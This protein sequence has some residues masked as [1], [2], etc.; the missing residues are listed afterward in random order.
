MNLTLLGL[1]L[2]AKLASCEI[3]DATS[4]TQRP[5]N[6]GYRSPRF[7]YVPTALNDYEEENLEDPLTA[8]QKFENE[9]VSLPQGPENDNYMP[10]IFLD[11]PMDLD[12]Y[13]SNEY[14]GD[15][16]DFEDESFEEFLANLE[17]NKS[18]AVTVLILYLLAIFATYGLMMCICNKFSRAAGD[19]GAVGA[20]N[21]GAVGAMAPIDWAAV[22]A[23]MGAMDP[24]DL[25]ILMG[26]V[27]VGGAEVAVAP[28]DF[29]KTVIAMSV[30]GA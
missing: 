14:S 12:D 30:R 17:K 3:E 10:P 11:V 7:L 27:V 20:I 8:T 21:L 26:A 22:G 23:A 15:Y 24:I 13:E 25:D 4:L 19:V 5:K 28:P 2:L 6:D 9:N 29:S 18:W 16:E 1:F